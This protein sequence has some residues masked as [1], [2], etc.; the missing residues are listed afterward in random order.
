MHPSHQRIR[1]QSPDVDSIRRLIDHTYLQQCHLDL[2][3]KQ[4][5]LHLPKTGLEPDSSLQLEQPPLTAQPPLPF[6][7]ISVVIPVR[8]EAERL[9]RAIGALASQID[10]TGQ[11][12]NP[13][14]YEVLLVANNCTDQTVEVAQQ[15][16]KRYPL[17]QLHIIEIALPKE[18]ACVG[19][20]RQIAMNEAYRRLSLIGLEDRIIA[21]TDGDTEV[22]PNWIHSLF[23]EFAT[24]VDAVG[25]RI[26]TQRQ[27]QSEFSTEVSLY[28]LRRLAHAY[29][30]AQIAC[31]LDPQL[32]DC[33]PRHF[34][35][36]GANMAVSAQIYGQ[37]GGI[38]FVR[39]EE[40]V[41]LYRRL[42]SADAKIRHSLNVRVQ[43]SARLLGRATGGLS[44]LLTTLSYVT[45]EQRT[46]W[47]E[48]PQVTEARIVLN[49]ALRK[50]W[51]TLQGGYISS[52][53][54]Y[55]RV[56]TLLARSIGLP[57]SQ[58]RQQIETSPTFG[59]LV[60]TLAAKQ[61]EQLDLSRF[62]QTT[63]ISIANMHLRQRLQQARQTISQSGALPQPASKSL[64]VQSHA[65]L[66]LEAL[67]QV[68]AIPLLPP[69]YS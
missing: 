51:L 17:L 61:A 30:A 25:G 15:L 8:N 42:Q 37:I 56:T 19:K 29:L 7:R 43:T 69:T 3:S 55:E 23:C 68:Q 32:H 67:Q 31:L 50:V 47:V 36:C 66:I 48:S 9:P 45:Q 2:N 1:I 35:Y 12:L 52:I 38:P 27:N 14:C 21:S 22:A 54:E 16:S 64:Y 57:D 28:Y 46:V 59:E 11:Q 10:D 40:D 58:L 6:C 24:G 26:I 4:A 62:D 41:A 44:A 33:W 39:D 5:H 20:A 60:A 49:R 18:V 53:R 63:E 34:Q 13:S 65:R